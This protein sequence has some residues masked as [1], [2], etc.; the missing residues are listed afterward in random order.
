MTT[1]QTTREQ[2]EAAVAIGAAL[3]PLQI[4][5]D[6]IEW[7]RKWVETGESD[8]ES[9]PW[10]TVEA[11][12]DI[13]AMREAAAVERER[14]RCIAAVDVERAWHR[15]A[16]DDDGLTDVERACLRR[17][18]GALADAIA[19]IRGEPTLYEVQARHVF[20]A[21][22]AAADAEQD[23][24]AA[25]ALTADDDALVTDDTARAAKKEG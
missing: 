24:R 13:L 8:D 4:D 11:A 16:A 3:R 12:L 1:V 23:R 10:H 19:A 21:E 9:I 17:A 15:A 5:R 22:V 20:D 14:E 2:R 7:H 18:E 6:A 25:R